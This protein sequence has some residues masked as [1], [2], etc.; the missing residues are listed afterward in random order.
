MPRKRSQGKRRKYYYLKQTKHLAVLHQDEKDL[1]LVVSIALKSPCV[2]TLPVM[3]R[4]VTSLSI[5]PA[6][7]FVVIILCKQ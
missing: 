5:L 4:W 1:V 7:M 3:Q 6:G 2:P